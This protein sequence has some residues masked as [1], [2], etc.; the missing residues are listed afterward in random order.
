[1]SNVVWLDHASASLKKRRKI[2]TQLG[3]GDAGHIN[4]AR[5]EVLINLPAAGFPPPDGGLSDANERA[6]GLTAQRRVLTLA[7]GLDGVGVIHDSQIAKSAMRLSTEKL[8][9][10][11]KTSKP[12]AHTLAG[13]AK[14]TGHT[15]AIR[16]RGHARQYLYIQ[17][18]MKH[19]GVSD[20]RLAQRIGVG[21]PTVWKRRTQQ[22]RLNPIKIAEIAHA[23]DL[24]P[25]D[26]W[27]PPPPKDELPQPPSLDSMLVDAPPAIRRAAREIVE[28]LLKASPEEIKKT[29]T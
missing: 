6:E 15:P 10:W 18:W 25:V 12:A 26:L 3:S 23:L 5:E 11:Q 20:E 21:T 24:A 29:G 1:M 9:T 16:I 8:P 13:M 28:S 22:H 27:R 14:M 19:L 7:K 4:H 17:E 2:G